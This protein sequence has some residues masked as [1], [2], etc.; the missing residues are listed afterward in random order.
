MDE[1]RA[2]VIPLAI[3][4]VLAGALVTYGTGFH[5]YAG[6]ACLLWLVLAL[7]S[8]LAQTSPV[9]RDFL[10]GTL[11]TIHYT[12][13]YR[14]IAR[15]LNDWIWKR[16]GRTRTLPDNTEA[17]LPATTSILQLFRAALT[18]RMLD[19]ALLLAIAY[20]AL[21]LMLQWLVGKDVFIVDGR[22]VFRE[23]DFLPYRAAVLGFFA[24]LIASFVGPRLV[25][26]KQRS[27]WR[28]EE[29]ILPAVVVFLA[30][31]V[32]MTITVLAEPRA[33]AFFVFEFDLLA[34][35]IES[36]S[37]E[38]AFATEFYFALFLGTSVAAA[39]ILKPPL[40]GATSVVIGLVITTL[41]VLY[42][43]TMVILETQFTYARLVL[44]II[45]ALS[46]YAF[47][48]LASHGRFGRAMMLMAIYWAL[49]LPLSATLLSSVTTIEPVYFFLFLAVL[50]LINGLFDVLSY[51][52]T[53]ALSRKGLST[54]WAPL[55]GL[56][57]LALGAVLFMVLGAAIV[58][59][60]TALNSI[61][62]EPIFSLAELFDGLG[63]NPDNFW[64]LYLM[65]F[66]TLAPTALHLLV[67]ALAVQ[68]LVLFQRPRRAVADWIKAAPSSHPAA[69]MAFLA[70]ATIWWLPLMALAG[71]SWV[72]WQV[73]GAAM[74]VAGRFYLEQL[75]GLARWLGSI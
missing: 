19:L 42:S 60:V 14:S 46:V 66:S 45:S 73:G 27:F 18:W 53:L 31:L 49:I 13:L 64:W 34:Y 35:G 22:T 68:G 8:L 5:P 62:T 23:N 74:S 59:T 58:T 1:P 67:A 24:A 25:S 30:A 50:P 12:P 26:V 7:I 48:W 33:G 71:L 11:Q 54:R 15:P 17:P 2:Y 40:P 55:W 65:L 56:T 44:P 47:V 28:D 72:L 9:G 3:W 70:Q 52:I 57:D 39:A 32:F 51:A 61:G 41:F 43:G 10:A 16:V 63:N 69:V 38:I 36:G 20:P 37:I 6:L 21:A 29:K 4:T 75:E